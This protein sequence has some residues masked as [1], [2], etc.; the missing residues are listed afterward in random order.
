M[1]HAGTSVVGIPRAPLC[2]PL[3][4]LAVSLLGQI[5][6]LACALAI[7]GI[8]VGNA[9]VTHASVPADTLYGTNG[10]HLVAIDPNDGSITPLAPQPGFWFSGLAFDS[11]GRLFAT[12]CSREGD[13]RPC[14]T[15]ST[16]LLME[17]DPL[18]GEVVDV[19]GPVTDVS[20]SGVR[21]TVLSV[22][23][24]TD[25][26]FG[27]DRPFLASSRIW[28]I[29]KSTAVATLVTSEVPAGCGDH[30]SPDMAFSF[31]PDGTLLHIARYFFNI[32]LMAL[33]PSTGAELSS[34]PIGPASYNGGLAVRSDGI[35]FTA[36]SPIARP[37]PPFFILMTIDPLTGA[38]TNVGAGE[39]RVY[40]LAFSPLV[41]DIDIK[42]GN[43]LNS[44]NPISRGIIPVA[45]LG[46]DSFDV[47]DVDVT[48][49]A[50]GSAVSFVHRNGPHYKDVN[51]DDF[52]DLLAHYRVKE[53]GIASGDQEA[54]VTGET[55][56]GVP[57]KGCDAIMTGPQ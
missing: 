49:L 33:D 52:A 21:I 46:S 1:K 2:T 28:T 57:F 16:P 26:L 25:L 53:T 39:G 22:Q 24:E 7:A 6:P 15:V 38:V 56:D 55:L 3:R 27:F 44:I 32:V 29:D 11:A 10:D 48:I 20:D 30:C 12:G 51:R 5:G 47:A 36:H 8:A 9:R 41:V 34:E 54:C 17:L 42:P 13:S 45:I 19:I 40:D 31:A 4:S 35:L 37:V 18:T 50:F 23:P 43:D 14:S